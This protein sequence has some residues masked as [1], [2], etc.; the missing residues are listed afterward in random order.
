[1]EEL[2]PRRQRF[3]EEYQKD[4][5]GGQAAIR[6][7]YSEAT[8]YSQASRLLRNDKVFS[9]IREAEEARG[10]RLGV[11]VDRV[12]DEL[13]KV[14]FATMHD[15]AKWDEYGVHF[16]HS[17]DIPDEAAATIK[18]VKSVTTTTRDENGE[19]TTKVTREVTLHDKLRA[20]ELLGKR[21]GMFTDNVRTGPMDEN[22]IEIEWGT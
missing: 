10:E 13:A 5:N 19:D 9:A 7:G 21:F 1:V 20:L 16:L 8:A 18:T 2:S 12:V 14:G 11:D 17:D 4:H 22:P 6:A 3:V 15:V